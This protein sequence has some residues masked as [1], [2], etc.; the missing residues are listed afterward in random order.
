M[1]HFNHHWRIVDTQMYCRSIIA[2]RTQE[3]TM[4]SEQCECDKTRIRDVEGWWEL[5][6]D[7]GELH[8]PTGDRR[9]GCK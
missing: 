8:A 3:I 1:F 5:S 7:N 4:L 9:K 6:E 2:G